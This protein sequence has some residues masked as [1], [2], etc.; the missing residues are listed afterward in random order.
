MP[1]VRAVC[2]TTAASPQAHVA[3]LPDEQQEA[4]YVWT[5]IFSQDL[6]STVNVPADYWSSALRSAIADIGHTV[7]PVGGGGRAGRC[8]VLDDAVAAFRQKKG[9]PRRERT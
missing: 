9:E 4:I 1:A 5:D 7:L 3:S 6:N 2:Q 8:A